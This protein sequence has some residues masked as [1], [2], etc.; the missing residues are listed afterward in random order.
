MKS[1]KPLIGIVE[2]IRREL[3]WGMA[4]P[5]S[6][7]I[8]SNLDEQTI[9]AIQLPALELGHA[10]LSSMTAA[11]E[12]IIETYQNPTLTRRSLRSEKE[13]VSNAIKEL[14]NARAMARIELR[15]ISDGLD[16]E[17]R[18]SDGHV[19]FPPE[20][21]NLC[22]FMISL[23]QVIDITFHGNNPYLLSIR[24][25]MKCTMHCKSPMTLLLHM[26]A[27]LPDYGILDFHG[28]G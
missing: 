11:R 18:T 8:E 1:I 10:I 28:H 17:Q 5:R 23:L 16:M 21:F 3:S 4:F 26:K 24:W 27:R 2:N 15:K 25:R 20:F 6:S 12:V 7:F 19:G 9:R 14:L 13:S 22:L